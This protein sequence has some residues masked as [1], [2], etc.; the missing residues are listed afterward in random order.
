[1]EQKIWHIIYSVTDK[2]EY[3]KALKT[4]AQ[5]HHLDEVSF[6][7]NFRK[8]PPFKSD[9]GSYSEKAIK[10]LLP[11]LRL[12]KYWNWENL[13]EKT[14]ERV[15]KII[16][17][18]YESYY[19][20]NGNLRLDKNGKP[21][22]DLISQNNENQKHWSIRKPLHTDN[23]SAEIILQF[24]RLKLIDNL[25]K[26]SSIIDE[27]IK[28]AVNEIL[29][30]FD[31]KIG[32][33]KKYVV[34]NPITINDRVVEYTDFKISNTKYRKR[35]PIANL[36]VRTGTGAL[37]TFDSVVDRINKVSDFVLR[38]DLLQHLKI[39]E[40]DIDK[41]FSIEGIN[42]F[43]AN[44]KIPVFRLP[45]SESA[46]L[47]F[48]IGNKNSNNHKWV[49]TGGNFHF[50]ITQQENSRGYETIPLRIALTIEKENL[51]NDKDV[52]NDKE[53]ILSPN[54]LVYVPLKND[55]IVNF[56]KLTIPQINRIYKFVSCTDKEAHF[57]PYSN[58]AEIV[59][60]ENGTNSKNERIQDFFDDNTI[61]DEKGKLIQVKSVCWKLKVDRL[62]N[63]SKS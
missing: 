50:K 38:N 56:D 5:K 52:Q 49:E 17:G 32:E 10:K 55:E 39:N 22:K 11:L 36:S 45:I 53:I 26:A 34:Q 62:G 30:M 63:I 4:F 54:D 46:S 15:E 41:A 20:E 44:R 9:Y 58:S 47:K 37:P 8:F 60:N 61:L 33:A 42:E 29:G 13:D 25:G 35:Q 16:T 23:P 31:G 43:N 3:E 27:K 59:K 7:E 1:M 48:K 24:D 57:V 28:D 19:D 40:N 51:L 14:K 21:Q 18:E 2:I 6:V 12:G